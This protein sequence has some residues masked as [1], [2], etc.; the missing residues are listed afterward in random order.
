M[1]AKLIW[2]EIGKDEDGFPQKKEQNVTVFVEEKEV[3][4]A[5]FYEAMRNGISVKKVLKVR[6]EDYELSKHSAD[7]G[8]TEYATEIE[9][10]NVSYKII[11]AFCRGK[12]RVELTCG[13]M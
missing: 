5:E 1:E 13:E 7:D 11:R 9:Y 12:S 8:Q 4:R 10:D 3:V 6:V 2:Y